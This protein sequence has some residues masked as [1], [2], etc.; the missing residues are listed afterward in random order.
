MRA[1]PRQALYHLLEQDKLCLSSECSLFQA[2]VDW[3]AT[4]SMTSIQLLYIV[5][6]NG[7]IECMEV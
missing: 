6:A 2:V 7:S 4:W 1:L 5:M 3:S